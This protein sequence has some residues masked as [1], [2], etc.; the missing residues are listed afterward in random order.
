M[1][2]MSSVVESAN[3]TKDVSFHLTNSMHYANKAE[4]TG[5]E[6]TKPYQMVRKNFTRVVNMIKARRFG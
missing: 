2:N 1:A 5:W 6:V 4:N 3:K